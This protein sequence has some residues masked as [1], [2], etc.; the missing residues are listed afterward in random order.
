[1]EAVELKQKAVSIYESEKEKGLEETSVIYTRQIRNAF[2]HVSEDQ[3]FYDFIRR[4]SAKL[5]KTSRDSVQ[6]IRRIVKLSSK[7]RGRRRRN[8][9]RGEGIHP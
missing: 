8:D 5:G 3:E 1:M 4:H 7:A 2:V 6:K 9:G